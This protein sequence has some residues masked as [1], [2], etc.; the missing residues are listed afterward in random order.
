MISAAVGFTDAWGIAIFDRGSACVG[1]SRGRRG[2]G[3]VR[4]RSAAWW[5]MR[6]RTR[7]RVR[8]HL[9]EAVGDDA[10]QQPKGEGGQPRHLRIPR[11]GRRR[12]VRCV[13]NAEPRANASGD[14]S[15]KR[16]KAWRTHTHPR[17]HNRGNPGGFGGSQPR[18]NLRWRGGSFRCTACSFALGLCPI[19]PNAR[20]V[21]RKNQQGP[22]P[23]PPK[24]PR[25]RAPFSSS[26][27][28]SLK[29][30]GRGLR[31]EMDQNEGRGSMMGW[32]SIERFPA[33]RSKS[34]S[35]PYFT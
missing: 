25:L 34:P 6:M 30:I 1:V 23:R 35:R 17:T 10:R 24:L 16:A 20:R 13:R 27:P 8:T 29:R 21:R 14:R 3:G 22:N 28:L 12:G 33:M 9:H 18:R 31:G 5:Q 4:P 2:C 15:C 19:P 26:P 7:M 11:K 32:A